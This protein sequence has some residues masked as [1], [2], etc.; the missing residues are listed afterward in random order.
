MRVRNLTREALV[1]E[2]S[3]PNKSSE[4]CLS[5]VPQT[6]LMVALALVDLAAR[7]CSSKSVRGVEFSTKEQYVRVSVADVSNITIR[8]YA[9]PST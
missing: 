2:G 5:I 9:T 4:S 7:C 8:H 3:G 1:P 6:S